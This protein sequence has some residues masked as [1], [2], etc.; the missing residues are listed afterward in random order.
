MRSSTTG[1]SST[2]MPAV[3]SSN[4]KNVG[5][6]RHHHRD[7]ELALVAMRQRRGERV[8]AVEQADRIEHGIGARDEIGVRAPGPPHVVVNAGLGLGREAH[9]FSTVRLG[10]QVGELEGA[11][12][13]QPRRAAGRSSG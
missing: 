6:Q 10:K 9:V 4:M 3:G 7:F 8:A 1:T 12:E 2:L 5:L 11:P 13:A